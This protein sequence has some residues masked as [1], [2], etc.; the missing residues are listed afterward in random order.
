[1]YL[2]SI[3]GNDK[4][5]EISGKL[6]GYGGIKVDNLECVNNIF[7]FKF[8]HLDCTSKDVAL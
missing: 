7:L 1:M 2:L 6:W 8:G 5:W 4:I 3:Y